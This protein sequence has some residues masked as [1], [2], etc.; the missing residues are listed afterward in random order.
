MAA[1]TQG[2]A[3]A[4]RAVA[5]WKHPIGTPVLVTK[6]DGTTIETKTR[7]P[8][9]VLAGHTAV[10]WLEGISGCYLLSRVKPLAQAEGR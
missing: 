10:I 3:A 9:E 8:A 6:D 2:L 1:R 4:K 5:A 7:S